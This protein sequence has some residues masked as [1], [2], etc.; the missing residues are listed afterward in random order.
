MYT[1]I[2]FENIVV[3]L[4]SLV[5]WW[6]PTAV[7]VRR[8]PAIVVRN[9]VLLCGRRVSD[10]RVKIGVI[11]DIVVCNDWRGLVLLRPMIRDLWVSMRGFWRRWALKNANRNDFPSPRGFTVPC[12]R[13][14]KRSPWQKYLNDANPID[15]S[16]VVVVV[17]PYHGG[18]ALLLCANRRF[19]FNR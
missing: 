4:Y 1:N 19:G 16:C 8:R 5:H 10:W 17:N 9:R 3:S 15:A 11:H 13:C 2:Q 7:Y 14:R 18:A 6:P 12:N